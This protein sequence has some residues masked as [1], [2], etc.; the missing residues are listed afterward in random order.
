MRKLAFLLLVFLSCSVPLRAQWSGGVDLSA[1]FGGMRSDEVNDEVPMF[2][3]LTQG[4]FL[5]NYKSDQF[6]WNNRVEGKW[7]PKAVFRLAV[8]PV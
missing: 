2:H 3:G 7:E 1:G 8:L 6:T 4:V 5:L